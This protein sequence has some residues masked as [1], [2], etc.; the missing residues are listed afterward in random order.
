MELLAGMHASLDFQSCF[1][2]QLTMSYK[3]SD[4][5]HDSIQNMHNLKKK[6]KKVVLMDGLSF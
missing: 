3:Y 2:A 5:R 6:K 1:V 4:G